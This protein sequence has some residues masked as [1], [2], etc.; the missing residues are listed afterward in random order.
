[1]HT[2]LALE[3]AAKVLSSYRSTLLQ[4][5]ILDGGTLDTLGIYPLL[6]RGVK[7][8]VAFLDDANDLH[9]TSGNVGF[10]FGFAPSPSLTSEL[11]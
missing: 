5:F 9:A 6:R 4:Q 7:R 3:A 2:S 10:V 1:M 8:I 11:S